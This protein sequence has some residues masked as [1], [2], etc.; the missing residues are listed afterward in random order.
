M[1]LEIDL[2]INDCITFRFETKEDYEKCKH[3]SA[4]YFA[5]M[6]ATGYNSFDRF[7]CE[8]ARFPCIGL[9]AGWFPNPN[10]AD[11]MSML[12]LYPGIDCKVIEE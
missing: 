2:D 8:P 10:G 4:S 5:R 3:S 6:K 12:W 11:K 9:Q 1:K 7:D